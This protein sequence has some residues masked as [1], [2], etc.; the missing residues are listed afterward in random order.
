MKRKIRRTKYH[1]R[2]RYRAKDGRLGRRQ[3]KI[4]GLWF[5]AI[6]FLGWLNNYFFTPFS[7][8][9]VRA[10]DRSSRY[11]ELARIL[12]V[13]RI[14]IKKTDPSGVTST[15]RGNVGKGVGFREDGM[16]YNL[17]GYIK[18]NGELILNIDVE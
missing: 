4:L 1:I 18:E 10:A 15:Y 9:E 16:S 7:E 5:G 6:I 13:E 14:I 12:G 8:S 2:Y 17:K 11:V 3:L